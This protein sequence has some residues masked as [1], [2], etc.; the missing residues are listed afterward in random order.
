MRKHN[1]LQWSW[2]RYLQWAFN[3]WIRQQKFSLILIH[4]QNSVSGLNVNIRNNEQDGLLV[5]HNQKN[6]FLV[7]ETPRWKKLSTSE[8]FCILPLSLT[9]SPCS[10]IATS[11]IFLTILPDDVQG[12][13]RWL[14]WVKLA[15]LPTFRPWQEFLAQWSP[16]LTWWPLWKT[17]HKKKK[18][19]VV[20]S[21]HKI[22]Y[23][24]VWTDLNW[25]FPEFLTDWIL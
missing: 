21:Q 6:S 17:T 5:R 22:T 23:H 24:T 20:W 25:I 3:A 19:H 7:F 9:T 8:F 14:V 11:E 16:D 15:V 13:E 2:R 18:N 10:S 1:L 12:H 4:Y